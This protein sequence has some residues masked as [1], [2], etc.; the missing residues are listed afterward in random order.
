MVWNTVLP[1]FA[2]IGAG[3]LYGHFSKSQTTQISNYILYL[4]AP[5]LIVTS[6]T[7]LTFPRR[8]IALL[9]SS[10]LIYIFLPGLLGLLVLDR[11]KERALFLPVMFQNTGN[12]GLPLSLL[13]WGEAGM[14]KAIILYATTSISLYTFG[15]WISAGKGGWKEVLK[16][17]LVYA[18]LIAIAMNNLGYSMP[19]PLF[20]AVDMIGGTT[21]PLL[22]FVLGVFLSR[23][24]NVSF[25]ET[26]KGVL[27]RVGSGIVIGFAIVTV[28]GVGGLTR[29]IILLYSLMPSAVMTTIIADKYGKNPELVSAVVF[30]G[31]IVSLIL[32]PIMLSYLG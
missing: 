22:L 17:P 21:I 6:L 30:T 5:C 25:R 11:R 23:I 10:D 2:I 28:L 14:S 9:I 18:V 8:E 15:V 32:I 12:L 31:T 27:L 19:A 20:R 4:A 29:N 16:L 7:G 24:R 13:A 26:V 3:V 1:T